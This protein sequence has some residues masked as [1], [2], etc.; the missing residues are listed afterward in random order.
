MP[1]VRRVP[2]T[3]RFSLCGGVDEFEN[4][5]R[6]TVEERPFRAASHAPKKRAS[7]PAPAAERRKSA[8]HGASR[9]LTCEKSAQP[10]RGDRKVPA[11]GILGSRAFFCAPTWESFWVA[12]RRGPQSARVSPTGVEGFSAAF[13]QP[14]RL[15]ALAAEVQHPPSRS[16]HNGNKTQLFPP[17][18]ASM[19]LIKP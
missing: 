17:A 3:T 9:G 18:T 15:T 12:Q 14:Q 8:A 10:R 19:P 7:A 1:Q 11:P 4:A 6:T 2:H 16:S 5:L 13:T